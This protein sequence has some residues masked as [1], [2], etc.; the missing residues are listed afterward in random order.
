MEIQEKNRRDIPLWN[1]A[2]LGKKRT[3]AKMRASPQFK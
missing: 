3:A 1:I 2:A